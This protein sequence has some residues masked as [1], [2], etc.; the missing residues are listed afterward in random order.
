MQD[1]YVE[2]K[3]DVTDPNGNEGQKTDT[4]YYLIDDNSISYIGT[5]LNISDVNNNL[6]A[7]YP[8]P[9]SSIVTIP[10]GFSVVKVYDI[11]G[12]ILMES[13]L[14]TLDISVLPQNVYLIK[15]HDENNNVSGIA[16]VIKQ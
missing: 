13:T 14:E 6:I 1:G 8:N 7:I 4:T 12:K 5:N 10:S 15:I 3:L 2:I 9:T 11:K 16:K